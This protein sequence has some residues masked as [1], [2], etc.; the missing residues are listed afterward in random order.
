[1]TRRN[2]ALALVVGVLAAA[3]PAAANV[4]PPPPP[5][6]TV[7]SLTWEVRGTVNAAEVDGNTLYVGGNFDYV[8]PP[9]TGLGAVLTLSNGEGQLGLP[10]IEGSGVRAVV[11]DGAGGWFIGGSFTRVGGLS[12]RNLAHVR[13]DLS[14][15]PAFC[16]GMLPA[17]GTQTA[18][19]VNALARSGTRLY[20]GG[21]WHSIRGVDRPDVAALDV[22]TGALT[23][24]A[25]GTLTWVE[26]IP[27][28]SGCGRECVPEVHALALA[29]SSLYVGG[30]FT[31]IGGVQRWSLA[32]VDAT[33]GALRT[34]F[35]GRLSSLGSGQ[36]SVQGGDEF[37][38]QKPVRGLAVNGSRLYVVGEFD[39][40]AGTAQENEPRHDGIAA[41]DT[42]TGA[43]VPA[44]DARITLPLASG[45]NLGAVAVVNGVIYVGGGFT[46]VHGAG[47]TVQRSRLAAFT[48]TG[49][50][51]PWAPN[52][53]GFVAAISGSPQ[54][55]LVGGSFTTIAGVARERVAAIAAPNLVPSGTVAFGFSPAMSLPGSFGAAP[56][57]NAVLLGPTTAYVGGTFE[58]IGGA[59][60]SSLA[61]FD[62][63]TGRATSW[64]P[65]VTAGP[66]T[67]GTVTALA[68]LLKS[69][70]VAGSFSAINGEPRARLAAVA[71]DTGQL[72]PWQPTTPFGSGS[73]EIAALA[74]GPG[75]LYVGGQVSVANGAPFDAAGAF[76]A[77]T[78]APLPWAPA[79]T[80]SR[81]TT[82]AV[83]DILVSGSTVYLAG[84]FETAGG[85]AREDVAAV[86]AVT[87]VPT[88]FDVGDLAGDAPR[89]LSLRA[90]TAA[91]GR[92]YVGGAFSMFGGQARAGAAA[93]NAITGALDPWAPNPASLTAI[94]AA[95]P[96]IVTT[97][98]LNSLTR[99][100]TPDAAATPTF[101]VDATGSVT[102]LLL[103]P[104][105]SVIVVGGFSEIDGIERRGLAVF[106]RTPPV[107]VGSSNAVVAKRD[108]WSA[109]I[110]CPRT[111]TTRC[112]VDATLRE[113]AT[114][115]RRIIGR[116]H[117][118]I[119][120]GR[121]KRAVFLLTP[122]GL[123]LLERRA[124]VPAVV[125]VV[126]ADARGRVTTGRRTFVLTRPRPA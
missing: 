125:D 108:R 6:S 117:L 23:T 118:T 10:R 62:L 55:I 2:L 124:R 71:I 31:A 83:N 82:L 77:T 9:N 11:A 103:G 46:T 58:F 29:G 30:N 48:S 113:Q 56:A 84:N 15:D 73:G 102:D 43:L 65:A 99:G 53:D 25:A 5:V 33:T 41:L 89:R 79:L 64:A 52:P 67:R 19:V 105:V 90:G 106:A 81:N 8:G 38:F 88:G 44:F 94:L 112:T 50:V 74:T 97:R 104:Q 91:T 37:E 98:A 116:A 14:V 17:P 7:P 18:T 96:D 114:A 86:D 119:P 93:V 85:V 122:E 92:L 34:G 24:F 1:M 78:G 27:G 59:R 42:G 121:A 115:G 16:G 63:T 75:T 35:D 13:A 39:R 36:S 111:A 32:A 120:A 28:I 66:S 40:V 57:V 51:L 4:L 95:G 26:T 76:D 87:A 21:N 3:S 126:A 68:R 60:R 22:A 12:C 20:V 100:F 101:S 69:I 70:Y 45:R 80:G 61:A 72:L 110:R 49:A 107:S 47:Q 123:R 54:A 109:P